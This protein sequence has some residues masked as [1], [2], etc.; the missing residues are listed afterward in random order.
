MK[1]PLSTELYISRTKPIPSDMRTEFFRDQ[2]KIIHS[3]PFR[4]LKHKTQVFYA[5]GNDHI[6]TRIEHVLHVATIAATVCRGMNLSGGDWALDTDMAYAIGLGHDLGHT[7]FGHEGEKE[8]AGKLGRQKAFLHEINSYRVVEHLANHGQGLNLTY[9]VKDGIICHNGEDFAAAGLRPS[10]TAND[11]ENIKDREYIPTTY[12]GCVVRVSD[13]VAYLGRDIE[14]AI[15]AGFITRADVPERVTRELGTTNTEIIS[16]L[17]NDI[18]DHSATRDTIGFS[19]A[20]HETVFELGKF[21]YLRIYYHEKLV[22]YRR[23]IRTIIHTLFDYFVD[24]FQKHGQDYAAYAAMDLEVDRNF[25]RYVQQLAAVYEREGW[26]AKTIV[27]DYIAGM[28]DLFALDC[29]RQ[30]SIPSPLEFDRSQ[31]LDPPGD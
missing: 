16:S 21:N 28:T 14:D 19:P 18:I 22:K 5:P 24:M 1:N 27:T 11:L 6:C 30:I 7:P 10:T 9:A 15:T 20:V 31:R 2:T 29:M 12:E 23:H 25:G 26:D 4:R 3:Y 17:I 8:L 13:R